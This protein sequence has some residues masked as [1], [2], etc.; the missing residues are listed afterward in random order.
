MVAE[1]V[2]YGRKTQ[3]EPPVKDVHIVWITA[4]LGCDGDSV[5][6]TAAT[7]PSIEDVLL[8]DRLSGQLNALTPAA[9][10]HRDS[11]CLGLVPASR[12]GDG[13]R[14]ICQPSEDVVAVV[15]RRCTAARAGDGGSDDRGVAG[16]GDC[17]GDNTVRDGR[18][19]DR[20]AL[21][22]CACW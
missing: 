20:A 15:V 22:R 9:A 1:A 18:W 21:W 4:G 12:E 14:A 11:P 13:V 6:I 5:S 2:P 3:K 8:G 10:A 19:R 17:A 7:Q 16:I